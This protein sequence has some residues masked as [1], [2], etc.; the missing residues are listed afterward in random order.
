MSLCQKSFV[1]DKK[2]KD[3]SDKKRQKKKQERKS[4]AN[5]ITPWFTRRIVVWLFIYMLLNEVAS[6]VR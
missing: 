4:I 1:N 5:V 2:W 3:K 6:Y